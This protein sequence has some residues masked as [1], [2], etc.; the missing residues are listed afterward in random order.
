[1]PEFGHLRPGRILV[2]AGE[3]RRA[4]RGTVKPLAFEGGRRRDSMGRRKPLVMVKGKRQLYC[5][6]L[7]PLFFRQSTAR[8]RVATVLHELFH[9]SRDFDGTLAKDRRH[10]NLGLRFEKRFRPL[11]RRYWRL[12]PDDVLA[13]FAHHGDVRVSMW[14]EKPSTFL[15][16]DGRGLRTRYGDEQ[17]FV[18]T[19]KMV[20]RVPKARLGRLKVPSVPWPRGA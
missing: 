10:A 14:L 5:I 11:E 12:V 7:R 19:V 17:L 4:S 20:T 6:T 13:P 2:V 9:I 1:M 3:A 16:T 8:T 18:G 15:P